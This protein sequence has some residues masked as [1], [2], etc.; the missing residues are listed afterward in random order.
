M[1]SPS[2]SL[3]FGLLVMGA[4]TILLGIFPDVLL[5]FAAASIKTLL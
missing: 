5:K 1:P 4:A 2:P 3:A